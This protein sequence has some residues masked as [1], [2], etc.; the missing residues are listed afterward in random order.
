MC[1]NGTHLTKMPGK[2][3]LKSLLQW[4]RVQ[5]EKESKQVGQMLCYIADSDP[6]GFSYWHQVLS[7]GK[8]KSPLEQSFVMNLEFIIIRF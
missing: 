1:L 6:G 2:N 8:S 3:S 7:H 4:D 5:R